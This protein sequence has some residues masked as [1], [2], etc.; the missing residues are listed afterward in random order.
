MRKKVPAG[1]VPT[2]RV[3]ELTQRLLGKGV[4]QE[5]IPTLDAVVANF[6]TGVI[7]REFPR[8]QNQFRQLALALPN[9]KYKEDGK[10][11]LK[12]KR[13]KV[14]RNGYACSFSPSLMIEFRKPARGTVRLWKTGGAA[15]LGAKNEADAR[16]IAR[17]CLRNLQ[18]RGFACNTL[19]NF[20]ISNLLGGSKMP[21]DFE[22]HSELDLHKLH[23][24]LGGV[25]GGSKYEPELYPAL[26]W[27]KYSVSDDDGFKIEDARKT[28]T[29]N[30]YSSGGCAYTGFRHF[31]DVLDVF[32]H[33]W[34]A[35]HVPGVIIPKDISQ[36]KKT[37]KRKASGEPK[38]SN[39]RKA[40]DDSVSSGG[41]NIR[42]RRA[43]RKLTGPVES[44]EHDSD[45][46]A[47]GEDADD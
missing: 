35:L 10:R 30:I 16:M 20:R 26:S 8:T 47:E 6:N 13:E 33:L 24:V 46:D 41:T 15:V 3:E 44:Q 21:G 7:F 12:D 23:A 5:C 38:K 39:K 17:K 32:E 25:E 9:T 34:A 40:T 18:K 1:P 29:I 19:Q 31:E 36:A 27:Q 42:K 28:M 2:E 4:P 45:I 37:H 22:K 14:G 43:T 11:V